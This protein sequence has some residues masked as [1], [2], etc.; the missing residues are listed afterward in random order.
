MADLLQSCFTSSDFFGSAEEA[1]VALVRERSKVSNEIVLVAIGLAVWAHRNGHTCIDLDDISRIVGDATGVIFPSGDEFVRVLSEYPN[2]VRVIDGFSVGDYGQAIADLRPIVL[3]EHSLFTQRQFADELSIA[4]QLFTRLRQIEASKIGTEWADRLVCVPPDDDEEAKRIGDDGIANRVAKSVLNHRLTVLT[5]GPGTGKTYTLTRC[6]AAFLASR[7]D[8][9][10]SV[11][12]VAPTGKAATRAKQLITEFVDKELKI[13]EESR[14]VPQHVLETLQNIEPKTIQRVLGNK[15]RQQ[16]RFLHD[17]EF[18]LRYDI[19]IV[20]EMSMVPSY[21]MA[22]LLEAIQKDAT[23]LLVGDQAQLESVESGSVLREVVEYSQEGDALISGSV[24]ELRRIW[25][26]KGDTKIGD[27]ARLI[28]AGQ[29]K[30]AMELAVTNPD[31]VIFI[32]IDGEHDVSADV[33]KDFIVQLKIARECATSTSDA[34]HAEA[35]K[36]ISENKILCGPRE[37]LRG[38]NNWNQIIQQGVQGL[39]DGDIMR[40]G[41]PLLVTVNSPRSRLVNGDIGIVVNFNSPDG[42]IETRIYFPSEDGPRYLSIAELPPVEICY[43]MT[44]HKSQGSE[45][46]NLVVLLPGENSPLSTRELIYTAV[47]RAKSSVIIIGS[48]ASFIDAVDNVSV[49]SAGLKLLL[50][51]IAKNSRP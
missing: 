51:S 20:D 2:I 17:E 39:L 24:F 4:Q 43:A 40:P 33:A 10:I 35:F 37:G 41:T 6:L 19:V 3:V 12:L 32:E 13:S 49:R 38:V 46:R 45:Y 31:G 5:G 11:A 14:D 18:Q 15:N 9:N 23:I 42:V 50:R 36:I 25:R 28:R 44:I 29:S 22:R 48:R 1:V 16:T 21:L 7:T 47:T 30:E 27:L 26:Q 8:K 34:D